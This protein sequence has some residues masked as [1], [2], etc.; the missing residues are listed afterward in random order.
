MDTIHNNIMSL[1]GEEWQLLLMKLPNE[2]QL[3][4]QIMTL[5]WERFLAFVHGVPFRQQ[6]GFA[7]LRER[8][9]LPMPAMA[10]AVPA[11]A[12]AEAPKTDSNEGS[13]RS[14]LESS[15]SKTPPTRES[16][17]HKAT[18][19]SAK[20]KRKGSTFPETATDTRLSAS[21]TEYTAVKNARHRG[22]SSPKPRKPA[23]LV[24][25]AQSA[26]HKHILRQFRYPL[27]LRDVY[28]GHF[29]DDWEEF[30]LK[31]ETRSV[32]WQWLNGYAR[33]VMKSPST[34][35]GVRPLI[36][37]EELALEKA[38]L[39]LDHEDGMGD[40]VEEE[41]KEEMVKEEEV[42]EEAAEDV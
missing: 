28:A 42:K 18:D 15:T 40:E 31:G 10:L 37:K 25:K 30:S 19:E 7:L 5:P 24:S 27:N 22:R 34:K 6:T 38:G 14:S 35:A 20:R 3:R 21:D 41:V 17:S 11:T 16:E 8:R 36:R 23:K 1:S 39:R 4:S 12:I 2:L 26:R 33:R 32:G 13:S 9:P 29:G